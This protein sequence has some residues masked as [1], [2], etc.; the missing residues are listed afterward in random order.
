MTHPRVKQYLKFIQEEQAGLAITLLQA[1]PMFFVKFKQ[2]VTFLRN[3]IWESDNLPRSDKYIL[4]RDASFFVVNFFTGD[5]ASDLGRLL[6][7]QVFR[8]KDREGFLLNQEPSKGSSSTIYLT[9]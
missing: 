1:V 4:V 6:T 5:R 7:S 8:L 2:L 9:L 3:L